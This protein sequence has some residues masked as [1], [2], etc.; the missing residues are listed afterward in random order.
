MKITNYILIPFNREL[1]YYANFPR[2]ECIMSFIR[3]ILINIK[4]IRAI[5]KINRVSLLFAISMTTQSGILLLGEFY[6]SVFRELQM[7]DNLCV[8]VR[9]DDSTGTIETAELPIVSLFL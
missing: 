5:S 8:V 6:P 1:C 9:E 3:W 4:I 7:V 2:T